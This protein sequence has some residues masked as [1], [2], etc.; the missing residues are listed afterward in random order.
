MM[1]KN[2]TINNFNLPASRGGV[3]NN[4]NNAPPAE[5]QANPGNAEPVSAILTNNNRQT[6]IQ[7]IK[8]KRFKP[9]V[10]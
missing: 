6:L 2:K 5:K 1:E 9:M 4:D 8:K 3:R 7:S 10:T